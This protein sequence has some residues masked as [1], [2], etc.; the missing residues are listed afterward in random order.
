M[1]VDNHNPMTNNNIDFCRSQT[2]TR[3]TVDE[4]H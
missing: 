1:F 2:Y 3:N 4:T